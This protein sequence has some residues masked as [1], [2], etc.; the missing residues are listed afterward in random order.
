MSLDLTDLG[1]IYYSN[2]EDII[3]RPE[4]WAWDN[5]VV[6]KDVNGILPQIT[7][8][9]ARFEIHR[10]QLDINDFIVVETETALAMELHSLKPFQVPTEV[11]PCLSVIGWL[12]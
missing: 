6:V 9:R 1:R 4:Q 3:A 7:L 11:E 8:P 2:Q 5:G 12:L 10:R